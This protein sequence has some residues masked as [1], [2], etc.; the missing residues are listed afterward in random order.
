MYKVTR[1]PDHLLVEFES[2][3]TMPT[4]LAAL[5]EVTGHPDYDR[6]NDLWTFKRATVFLQLDDLETLVDQ[7]ELNYPEDVQRSKTALVPGPGF[8]QFL[9]ESFEKSAARLPFQLQVFHAQPD[10]EGWL[11]AS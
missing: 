11:S 10:A 8:N 3:V 4:I 2:R 7:I 6:L 1:K 9:A 5:A